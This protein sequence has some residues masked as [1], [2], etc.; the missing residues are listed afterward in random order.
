MKDKQSK[1]IYIEWAKKHP[2]KLFLILFLFNSG[3]T[4]YVVDL[5]CVVFLRPLFG[6]NWGYLFTPISSLVIAVTIVIVLRRRQ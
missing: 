3:Y 6:G 2:I 5:F 1:K 4:F